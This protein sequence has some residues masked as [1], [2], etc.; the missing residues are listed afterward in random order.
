MKI[1]ASS[2]RWSKYFRRSPT[3]K[4]TGSERKS[5]NSTETKHTNRHTNSRLEAVNPRPLSV[6]I[7][8]G[9]LYS[10]TADLQ[11]NWHELAEIDIV[12]QNDELAP[13][14]GF[15]PTTNRLTADRSTTELRWIVFQFEKRRTARFSK[16]RGTNLLIYAQRASLFVKGF[17][18]E[19]SSGAGGGVPPVWEAG[20]G[21]G[22][23]GGGVVGGVVEKGGG[24]WDG[25]MKSC[26]KTIRSPPQRT[27]AVSHCVKINTDVRNQG[28]SGRPGYS[29]FIAPCNCKSAFCRC[30][31]HRRPLRIWSRFH[32]GLCAPS[33][34]SSRR[35]Y[36]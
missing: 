17:V 33:T 21:D 6:F 27:M 1:P 30:G 11:R 34:N 3:L 12:G 19:N 2:Q 36:P 7:G 31:N 9:R 22:E 32:N 25:Y 13:A 18:K 28:P 16:S 26:E 29:C 4:I 10:N 8:G 14:V 23:P 15:E 5:K 24:Y 35:C 20:G